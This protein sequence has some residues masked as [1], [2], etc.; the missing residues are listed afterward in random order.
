MAEKITEELLPQAEQYIAQEVHFQAS[1][2][3]HQ[4]PRC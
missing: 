4:R 1:M 2:L 3:S